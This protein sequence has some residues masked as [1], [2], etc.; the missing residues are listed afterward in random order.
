[1]ETEAIASTSTAAAPTSLPS[2]VLLTPP[3]MKSWKLSKVFKSHN[4]QGKSYTSLSFDDRG[5]M[6]ITSGEDETMQLF[7]VRTGKHKKQLYSKKYGV[8]LAR[9]THKSSTVIYAS[10]KGN[11]DIRYL[12]LHDNNYLRYF[13]GHKK[14]VTALQM[15]PVDDTFLSGATD[16]TV[17][18]WDLRAPSA[19]GLLNVAGHPCV[20]YDPSGTVF[21]VVLNLRSTVMLYDLSQFDKQPFLC[22]HIDDPVLRKRTYPPRTPIYTSVSFS[23]DGKWLL[24]GTSGDVHYVLDSFEGT[25]VARLECPPEQIATGLERAITAPYDRPM[26]PAAGISSEEVRWTPD[27][28]YVV[29][30]SVD[31]RLHVWDVAPPEAELAKLYPSRPAPGPEC[32]LH[33]MTS[34]EGHLGGPSRA[35][36]FNPRQ[37]M[38]ASAGFELAFWLPSLQEAGLVKKSEDA[39]AMQT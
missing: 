23:N 1:M 14:P 12:S 39:A 34:F 29:S 17:R 38:M 25:V 10:T 3:V 32:T 28:R 22:V 30:G 13:K 6:L 16:D 7:D 27:G 5:E 24:V 4:E 21:A 31:G 11:D 9:F 37:A 18:L 2:S 36:A 26:E 33:P 8:H 19:Q 15:S 35:L 20:A